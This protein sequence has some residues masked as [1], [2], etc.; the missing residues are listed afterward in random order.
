MKQQFPDFVRERRIR[1]FQIAGGILVVVILVVGIIVFANWNARKKYKQEQNERA[2]AEETTVQETQESSTEEAS[3]EEVSTE[4]NQSAEEASQQVEGG[5]SVYVPGINGSGYGNGSYNAVSGPDTND[6]EFG[7][8]FTDTSQ[9][10]T[11]KEET[12]LRDVPG[13]QGECI[14]TLENGDVVECTGIGSNG[15]SRVLYGGQTLYAKTQYLTDDLEPVTKSKNVEVNGIVFYPH[16]D[17]VTAKIE[18][19]LRTVPSSE[20]SDTIVATIKN[21]EYVSRIGMSERGW[22]RIEYQGQV[23]YAISSYLIN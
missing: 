11:A 8:S 19:N 21:G 5:Q 20:S 18:T 10:M 14:A 13:E 15:W 3:S 16:E 22:S 23:L 12:N 2:V 9:N 17:S 4:Q 7:V 1:I 6:A